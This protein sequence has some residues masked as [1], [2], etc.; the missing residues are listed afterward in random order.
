MSGCFFLKHIAWNN[1][2]RKIGSQTLQFHCNVRL[3]SR[4]VVCLS[5]VIVVV[6]DVRVYKTTKVMITR[7]LNKSCVRS[8]FSMISLTAKFEEILLIGGLKG[9]V[10][11]D[12]VMLYLGSDVR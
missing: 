11:L 5:V 12:F 7:F 3:L 9:L 6:C 1:A 8:F 10:V 2:F 4:Y